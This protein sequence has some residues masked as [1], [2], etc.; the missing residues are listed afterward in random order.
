MDHIGAASLESLLCPEGLHLA[1]VQDIAKQLVDVLGYLHQ[2]SVV[3]RDLKVLHF[4]ICKSI[5]IF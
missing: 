3:H 1:M 4:K 2:K 5:F